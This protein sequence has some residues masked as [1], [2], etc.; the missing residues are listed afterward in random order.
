MNMLRQQ[1]QKGLHSIGIVNLRGKASFIRK[2]GWRYRSISAYDEIPGWLSE[3]EAITLFELA[4][5]LPGHHS[6]VVEIGSWLGKSSLVIAKGLKKNGEGV[7]YCIDPF[8]ADG[9]EAW[10]TVYS[11]IAAQQKL[12]LQEQFVSNMKRHRTF[13]DIKVLAGYSTDFADKF[14]HPIDLLFI[15]GNHEFEAVLQDYEQ[16]SPLIK[17]GGII[18]FHDVVLEENRDP[19]GPRLVAQKFIL[20]SPSWSNVRLVDSLLVAERVRV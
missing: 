16:W 15:D 2:R 12:P 14:S 1:L 19:E 7:L 17:P 5:S 9:D 18:A 10:T 8:N 13:D 3:D 4:G 11:N 6:V 20:N